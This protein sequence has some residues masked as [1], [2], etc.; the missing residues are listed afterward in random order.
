MA[1]TNVLTNYQK[2][3]IDNKKEIHESLTNYKYY[4][5]DNKKEIHEEFMKRIEFI[6]YAKR[7]GFLKSF[8]KFKLLINIAYC[9]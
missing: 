8:Q 2:Y 7:L 4:I 5:I 1:T 6:G 3:L 9:M